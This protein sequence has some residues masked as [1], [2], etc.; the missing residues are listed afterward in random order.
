MKRFSNSLD[1]LE[2]QN[3][4]LPP[5]RLGHQRMSN[6]AYQLR[7]TGAKFGD[8]VFNF[9]RHVRG[10]FPTVRCCDCERSLGTRDDG[11]AAGQLSDCRWTG[12]GA[13]PESGRPDDDELAL[14]RCSVDHAYTRCSQK[15]SNRAGSGGQFAHRFHTSDW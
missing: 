7:P 2:R 10:D 11:L 1:A 3:W 12:D 4:D 6:G 15:Q 5:R 9:S 14:C 13:R 8:A